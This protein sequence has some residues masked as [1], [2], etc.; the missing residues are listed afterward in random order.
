M[1]P[2]KKKRV[3]SETFIKNV[4]RFN[5]Q[6]Q[7]MEKIQRAYNVHTQQYYGKSK[8]RNLLSNQ[9][10][11]YKNINP[12]SLKPSQLN[13]LLK[14]NARVIRELGFNSSLS[15]D[16]A[17]ASVLTELNNESFSVVDFGDSE[18]YEYDKDYA[19]REQE[20]VFSE[21]LYNSLK[22]LRLSRYQLDKVL[23]RSILS[24]YTIQEVK[25]NL[26]EYWRR[27]RK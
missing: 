12:L 21:I 10:D 5:K 23:S 8:R 16:L 24:D 26:L 17:E 2:P 27:L 19:M 3:Y 4:E 20:R 14:D 9:Y 7:R 13:Q 1:S 15:G 25:N 18:G 22:E 6:R 11:T